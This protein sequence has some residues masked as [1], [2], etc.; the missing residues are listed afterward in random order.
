MKKDPGLFI[1]RTLATSLCP[2]PNDW[3]DLLM[4][5]GPRSPHHSQARGEPLTGAGRKE[6]E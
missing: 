5:E 4:H 1:T 2:G 6:S 3:R